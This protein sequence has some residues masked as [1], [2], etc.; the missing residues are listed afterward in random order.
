MDFY[1]A[2]DHAEKEKKEQ[3]ASALQPSPDEWGDDELRKNLTAALKK[4][5]LPKPLSKRRS[6][7]DQEEV[8]PETRAKIEQRSDDD[9]TEA[10]DTVEDWK[11]HDIDEWSSRCNSNFR[12]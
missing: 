4:R 8:R 1:E 5:P 7:N 10:S 11:K 2:W 3:A 9:D 12:I 6:E